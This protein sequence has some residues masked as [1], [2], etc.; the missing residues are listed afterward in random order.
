MKVYEGP[1]SHLV[2]ALDQWHNS[3]SR[4]SQRSSAA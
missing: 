3:E 4:A 1:G 2:I